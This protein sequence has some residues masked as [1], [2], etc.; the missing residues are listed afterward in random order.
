M[1]RLRQAS[2]Q[3]LRKF[4]VYIAF[5]LKL[6]YICDFFGEVAERSKA[7]AWKACVSLRIPRVRIPLS[8]LSAPIY[9]KWEFRFSGIIEKLLTVYLAPEVCALGFAG[10]E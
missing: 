2:F 9:S 7:H 5:A 10:P 6:V 4:A 8:P 1:A 3:G